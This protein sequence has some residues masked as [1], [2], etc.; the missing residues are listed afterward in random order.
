MKMSTINIDN[1]SFP[2]ENNSSNEKTFKE[3][4]ILAK[5]V[6]DL[7]LPSIIKAEEHMQGLQDKQKVLTDHMHEQNMKIAKI[8]DLELKMQI[9]DKMRIYEKKLSTL[10]KDMKHLHEWSIKLKARAQKIEEV[11]KNI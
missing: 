11:Y 7:Y 8:H 10:K 4:G 5:G 1:K 2:T 3:A 6:I 9:F